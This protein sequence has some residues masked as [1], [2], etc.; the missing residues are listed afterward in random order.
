MV[1][2]DGDAGRG[3]TRQSED[4]CRSPDRPGVPYEPVVGRP[5][6]GCLTA[7]SL[8]RGALRPAS[9]VFRIATALRHRSAV[10]ILHSCLSPR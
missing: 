5:R 3:R 4:G 9:V 6:C 8:G 10:A 2:G 7:G 1:S